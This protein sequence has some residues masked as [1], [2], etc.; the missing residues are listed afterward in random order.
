MKV[1]AR[2]SLLVCLLADVCAAGTLLPE[3]QLLKLL[4]R[5]KSFST[6][7]QSQATMASA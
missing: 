3:F 5:T 6:T 4:A 7:H 2:L 1:I